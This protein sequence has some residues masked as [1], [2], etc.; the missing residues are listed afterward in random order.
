MGSSERR[1]YNI[2]PWR[3][4]GLSL[5]AVDQMAF[6]VFYS[7]PETGRILCHFD[8]AEHEV[9]GYFDVKITGCQGGVEVS[10]TAEKYY[11]IAFPRYVDLVLSFIQ[12][13]E[14]GL[15]TG[16]PGPPTESW[17]TSFERPSSL[18]PILHNVASMVVLALLGSM[19]VDLLG[20]Q[21]A[22]G[23][24][25]VLLSSPF[26]MAI[27]LM[28]TGFMRYGGMLS[29][30]YSFIAGF[31]LG[32]VEGFMVLAV[33]AWGGRLAM[34][35]GRWQELYDEVRVSTARTGSTPAVDVGSGGGR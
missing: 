7:N 5:R 3:A 20:L 31:P 10:A 9:D 21:E 14:Q 25:I 22:T 26:L 19:V 33:A 29:Y 34:Q 24:I 12:L 8:R 32:L 30:G 35:R 6:D 17:E 28:T 23:T 18:R 2:E 15:G 13:F 16:A 4:F 1:F 27:L 11:F